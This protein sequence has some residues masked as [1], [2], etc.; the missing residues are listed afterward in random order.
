MASSAL[1]SLERVTAAPWAHHPLAWRLGLVL[2]IWQDKP[3]LQKNVIPRAI[4][5]K[6]TK[7][8]EQAQPVHELTSA[9]CLSAEHMPESEDIS[10]DA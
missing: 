1:N 4:P 7:L 8:G 5:H 2:D 9:N 10:P 3:Y 6:G